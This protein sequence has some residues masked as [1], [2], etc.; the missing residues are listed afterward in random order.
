MK[1]IMLQKNVNN[2]LNI[3]NNTKNKNNARRSMIKKVSNA[4][5]NKLKFFDKRA[6]LL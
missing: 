4:M 3:E 2:F 1:A 5:K 6:N